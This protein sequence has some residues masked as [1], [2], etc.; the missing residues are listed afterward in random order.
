MKNNEF[1]INNAF[2]FMT[3]ARHISMNLV[4]EQIVSVRL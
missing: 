3:T 1:F 4:E 2:Q